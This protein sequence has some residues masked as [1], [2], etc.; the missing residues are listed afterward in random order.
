MEHHR[1][2]RR[3]RF[4]AGASLLAAV[5]ADPRQVMA[6]GVDLAP[7]PRARPFPIGRVRLRPGLF[8]DAALRNRRYVMELEPDRLLHM[9]RVTAGLPSAAEPLGGWEQPANE[10]R[11]HF[12]GHYLS[13]CALLHATLGDADVKVL[14][15]LM[16]GELAKCQAALGSGYLSAFPEE[17]FDRLRRGENVWAPFYT[18]HKIMAGLL[19]M[20]TL[21]G[22]AQA[23]VMLK[24]IA[25]W[26]RRYAMPLGEAHMARVLEREYGG[27]N[28]V[29]YDL[30]AV[31]GDPSYYELAR[32]FDHERVFAPLAEGRDELKGLHANTTIPKIIGAARRYELLGERRYRDVAE[33]FWRTVTGR[34]S[35]CTGGTSNEEGW[36]TDPGR[37]AAELSGYTQECCCT[38][39]LLKLTRPVFAWTADPACADYHERALWNGI[40]GTQ[41]PDDGMTVYYVP[42]ASGFWKLF[43]RPREAF[44]CC[45]GSGLESF[46]KLPDSVYFQDDAGLYVN[47]FVP[48]TLDWSE[49]GVTVVQETR[50]PEEETIRLVVSTR[51]PQRFV[52]RVR[53]P[54]WTAKGGCAILNGRPLEAFASPGSYLVLDRVFKDGD[55]LE[56]TL[57]MDLRACPMPDDSSL[58]AAV[59]GPIVLAGRLGR[60]GLTPDNLRAEPTKVR[61]VPEYKSEPVPAPTIRVASA[62]PSGWLRPVAGRP[63]EYET[64]GQPRP[65][66]LEPLYRVFD[67]R[68]AV[69][70]KTEVA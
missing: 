14:G 57:P 56:V 58:V 16:V 10:L 40:L 11:G 12:T 2:M 33:Y 46:A 15:E 18:L 38:Y 42:L 4:L 23:L 67:E 29:L 1:G 49:R 32:Q 43:G 45:T 39:N 69:Y 27:M 8:L 47:Q 30:G 66:R 60:E 59:H 35:Y 3:R 34:R 21:A 55:R 17:F 13:A 26:V 37:L 64:V 51:S 62:D 63:L 31:T 52:L 54:S 65:L 9:F 22:N 5:G 20:H 28:E 50:F 48:T 53:V 41:H 19:D 68:Y 6:A 70:W 44:W 7:V 24:G 25:G 61:Q 36:R